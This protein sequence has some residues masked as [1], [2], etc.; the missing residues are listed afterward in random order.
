MRFLLSLLLFGLLAACGGGGSALGN[1]LAERE[2]WST[3]VVEEGVERELV[4]GTRIILDFGTETVGA[5]AGCNSMGGQLRLDGDVFVVTDMAMT[6]MGC[7]GARHDQDDFVANFLAEGPR[8]E[9]VDDTL[10]LT[11]DTVTMRLVDSA[12]ANPD[13]SFVGTQWI[14]DGF[15][16]GDVAMSFGVERSGTLLFP[17]E[18]SV[19]GFDGCGDLAG[20]AEV[21]TGATGGPIEGDAEVQ[22]G[23]IE[24]IGDGACESIEY[25]TRIRAVLDSGSA[26]AEID[27][28]SMTLFDRQGRGISFRA[29]T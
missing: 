21:S 20:P 5:S 2:F 12:V 24:Y 6:E 8:A 28:Q 16:D 26:T 18:S 22:F 17:D 23:P 19:S 14:V 25:A 10:T 13:L 9:L 7:D 29:A 11:T 3:S 1:D 4:P 27:G 15:I